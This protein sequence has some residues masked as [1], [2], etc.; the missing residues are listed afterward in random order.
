MWSGAGG[1][2]GRP[3]VLSRAGSTPA[4]SAPTH[5][6]S[7]LQGPGLGSAPTYLCCPLLSRI[8]DQRLLTCAVCYGP[9]L[10]SAPTYLCFLLLV[11][12]WRQRLPTCAGPESGVRP[13]LPVLSVS[14]PP[15][16]F[17]TCL[18]EPLTSEGPASASPVHIN[19][20]DPRGVPVPVLPMAGPSPC[21]ASPCLNY[22]A[23]VPWTLW[24]QF[25]L[26]RPPPIPAGTASASRPGPQNP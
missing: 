18:V 25:C 13:S 12:T 19:A 8:W 5:L 22:P 20:L 14:G 24:D 4:G 26:G 21:K 6:C 9:G 11:R 3:C 1:R 7:P 23:G 2:A 17:H 10:G 16:P 15:H